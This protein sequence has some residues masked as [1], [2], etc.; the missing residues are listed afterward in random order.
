MPTHHLR[1]HSRNNF[2]AHVDDPDRE[3]RRQSRLIMSTENDPVP[4]PL[5]STTGLT[6]A[7]VQVMLNE[8][9]GSILSEQ[10]ERFRRV[11]REE[12]LSAERADPLARAATL[13]QRRQ[14][15]EAQWL[16]DSTASRRQAYLAAGMTESQ[17]DDALLHS[18]LQP[19]ANPTTIVQQPSRRYHIRVDD[20]HTFDGGAAELEFWLARVGS[21]Y[22]LKDDPAWKE[23][24]LETLPLCMRGSAAKWYQSS[25]HEVRLRDLASWDGWQKQLRAAFSI[26]SSS[27]R[28]LADRRQWDYRREEVSTYHYDKL[29]LLRAAYPHR[30]DADFVQE[31][32]DGLPESLQMSTRTI[33]SN[34]PAPN[35]F[36]KEVRTLEGPW[37][38]ADQRTR[39]LLAADETSVKA[40]TPVAAPN[41]TVG[42]NKGLANDRN[43]AGRAPLRDTYHPKNVKIIK[44]ERFYTVPGSN[45]MIKLERP[46][47]TCQGKHFTFEHDYLASRDGAGA[48]KEPSYFVQTDDTI[49]GYPVYCLEDYLDV[50]TSPTTSI[51]SIS[52]SSGAGGTT[53]SALTVSDTS[54]P[55]RSPSPAPRLVELSGN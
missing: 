38:G 37:R 28:R 10:E 23:Q 21:L 8:R 14:Q 32:W 12:R 44:G 26:D 16:Q 36:L 2:L 7:Q 25:S 22:D 24:I 41:K 31:L 19:P 15:A 46:C 29:A 45:C 43:P 3:A 54:T 55:S 34:H 30:S 40:E 33:M 50:S 51:M 20:L 6:A 49:E 1:S 5:D 13:Q 53:S 48:K 47:A 27:A 11:L 35:Q 39:R 42:P 4:P 9:L 18:P 17:A 52:S